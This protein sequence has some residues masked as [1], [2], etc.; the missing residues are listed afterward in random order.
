MDNRGN[1]RTNTCAAARLSG[2]VVLICNR[3]SPG[4]PWLNG[5]L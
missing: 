5:E 1:S 2:R 3:T 4:D